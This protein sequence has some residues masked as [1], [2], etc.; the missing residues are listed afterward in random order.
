MIEYLG[1][2]KPVRATWGSKTKSKNSQEHIPMR[3]RSRKQ[4]GTSKAR[5]KQ[6][7]NKRQGKQPGAKY[8]AER[9]ALAG[10]EKEQ[11]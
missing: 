3:R 11:T 8:N 9:K 2:D 4:E 6:E 1:C 10:E 5:H 7:K